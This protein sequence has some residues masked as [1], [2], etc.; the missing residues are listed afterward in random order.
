MVSAQ[1]Q[2]LCLSVTDASGEPVTDLTAEEL[3]VQWDGED[4]ET[5]NVE[6]INWPVR[7]TVYV[8]NG[9]GGREALQNMREGLKLFVDA[10]PEE[11]EVGLRLSRGDRGL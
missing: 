6:P 2:Q 7:L 11:V 10:L 1:A 8:D 3:I 4:C 9:A 5:L